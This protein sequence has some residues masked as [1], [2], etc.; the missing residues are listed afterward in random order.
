MKLPKGPISYERVK[1]F[2]GS[3]DCASHQWE[4]SAADAKA[5]RGEYEDC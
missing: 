5:L 4:Q 2:S 3:G 1:A